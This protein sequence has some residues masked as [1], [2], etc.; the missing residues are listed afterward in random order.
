ML[1]PAALIALVVLTLQTPPPP[2]PAP[3]FEEIVRMR[4]VVTVPGM[5]KVSVR[6]NVVYKTADGQPQHMDVYSPPG[7]AQPRPAVMLIH[8]GP[9][10]RLGAKNMG[11]YLSYGELLAAS[12]FVAVTFD[13]RFLAPERTS[14]AA[15]DVADAVAYVRKNA[16][17][18]GVDPERLALWAFSG[19]GRFLA[20]PLRERPTWLRAAAAFYAVLDA[21]DLPDDTR[22]LPPMLVG[23]AGL[24]NPQLNAGLDRFVQAALARNATIDVMNHAQ[25]HHAF[26]ILDDDA[27]SKEMIRRTLEFLRTHLAP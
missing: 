16:P 11:V 22:P 20:A 4:V 8:G 13:H 23:R 7:P 3:T 14:D 25:G 27:R 5:D 9:I 18:L 26:D 17:S 10:P 2:K 24:D 19:G 15:G 6:R 12:G 21:P 1:M